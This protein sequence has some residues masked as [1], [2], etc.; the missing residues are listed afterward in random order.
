MD[1]KKKKKISPNIKESNIGGENGDWHT[2]SL[3]QKALKLLI[4]AQNE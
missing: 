4:V 2:S 3:N 1:L